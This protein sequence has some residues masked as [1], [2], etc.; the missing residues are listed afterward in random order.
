MK[1]KTVFR[2][3]DCGHPHPKW[4]GKCDSCNSWNSLDE[5]IVD[6]KSRQAKLAHTLNKLL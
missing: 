2:C 4:Q 1:K 3:S 6:A 5:V